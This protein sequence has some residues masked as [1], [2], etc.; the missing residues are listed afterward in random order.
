[1]TKSTPKLEWQICEDETEW[2]ATQAA[3][4]Y[5]G[6]GVPVRGTLRSLRRRPWLLVA[7]MTVFLP[8]LLEGYREVRRA[9]QVMTQV[10]NEVRAAVVAE[11]WMQQPKTQTVETIV[12][13]WTGHARQEALLTLVGSQSGSDRESAQRPE[14]E[15][16]RVE[17][18]DDYAMVE[19]WRYASAMP[20]LP[21]P[22][23]RTL[24][25]QE[26]EQG[27]LPTD[28]PG[29]LLAAARRTPDRALHLRLWPSRRQRCAGGRASSRASRCEHTPGTV[30]ATHRRSADDQ[31]SDERFGPAGSGDSELLVLPTTSC[32]PRRRP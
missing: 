28:T 8:A 30:A 26:T 5:I 4:P 7:L 21:A 29:P 22:Y 25:Y 24:F 14:V 9:D 20:W 27:W 13:S 12:A 31:G 16:R 11:A 10:E 15:V 2:R 6:Q 23:R 18:R 3:S 19:V 32:S 17:V 1:M